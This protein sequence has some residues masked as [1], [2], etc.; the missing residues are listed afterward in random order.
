MKPKQL[1][2]FNSFFLLIIILL[3]KHFIELKQI[4]LE[5]TVVLCLKTSRQ[6]GKSL[7]E[8]SFILEAG[9]GQLVQLSHI[10]PSNLTR[11]E[12]RGAVLQGSGGWQE[13]KRSLRSRV[14]LYQGRREDIY[15]YL[16]WHKNLFK[17]AL[18][19]SI[20]VILLWQINEDKSRTGCNLTD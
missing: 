1:H 16:L 8:S 12:K 13:D 9:G 3:F 5:I 14:S 20:K 4:I 6:S 15:F 7:G 17:L 10:F 2:W 19:N 18:R 11:C